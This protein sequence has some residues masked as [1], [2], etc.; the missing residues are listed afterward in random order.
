[1]AMAVSWRWL[2]SMT[3]STT[4]WLAEPTLPGAQSSQ[5]AMPCSPTAIKTVSLNI[6]RQ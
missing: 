4:Q 2:K 5:I 6:S 3:R 1:M